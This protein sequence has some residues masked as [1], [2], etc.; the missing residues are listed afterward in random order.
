MGSSRRVV[1]LFVTALLSSSRQHIDELRSVPFRWDAEGHRELDFL[2]LTSN[3]T[4]NGALS[5]MEPSWLKPP[6]L[7]AVASAPLSGSNPRSEPLEGCLPD[8]CG[9]DSKE[10]RREV[11][12]PRDRVGQRLTMSDAFAQ[13]DRGAFAPCAPFTL[14]IDRPFL[15][16]PGLRR[17]LYQQVNRQ[18]GTGEPL[19]DSAIYRACDAEEVPPTIIDANT[20]SPAQVNEDLIAAPRAPISVGGEQE[21]PQNI[22]PP[23]CG[24]VEDLDAEGQDGFAWAANME[25]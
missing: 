9:L 21:G 22:H 2:I 14:V 6:L 10:L 17:A 24:E 1:I 25:P 8:L 15:A 16:G 18:P 19:T 20:V 13:L 3:V 7:G 12:R 11:R 5:Q 23:R 4:L